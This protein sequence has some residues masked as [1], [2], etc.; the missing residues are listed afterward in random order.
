MSLSAVP[1][2]QLYL[3]HLLYPGMTPTSCERKTSLQEYGVDLD[4]VYTVTGPV[5][6]I[7]KSENPSL[8]NQFV[9]EK[10]HE[11]LR[12]TH[13]ESHWLVG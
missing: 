6:R 7:G 5:G 3:L 1:Q 10:T 12:C 2:K 9:P 11:D 8:W 4:V 13:N